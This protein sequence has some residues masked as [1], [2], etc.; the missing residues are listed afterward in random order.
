MR[1]FLDVAYDGTA[2]HGSQL[3]GAT[4]TVQ[5]AVNQALCT[6]LRVEINTWG[7]SRTDE[8][9]HA[10]H[11]VYHF[12]WD[13]PLPA[14]FLYNLNALLPQAIA[15][16]RL[17]QATDSDLNARFAALSR[18]YRYRIYQHKDPFLFQRA[19]YYPFHIEPEILRETSS[20][21]L[22]YR[23]FTSFAKRNAQTKTNNCRIYE[24]RWENHGKELHYV[25][26]ADRFLRG[27]VR[28]LVGTQL[29]VARGKMTLDAFQRIIEN[30][31]SSGA[32]FGVAGWG[33]YLERIEYP[34]G[35]LTLV[36]GHGK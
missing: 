24:S 22:Y 18:Q 15:A 36:Q 30:K 14:T 33:L 11:N 31:D 27:M 28:A 2:F 9:V 12:D 34:E 13:G 26:R 25:V 1:Y 6:L 10:L 3:Q 7:A 8:G 4:P 35:A 19:L 17:W 29:K 20:L 16:P 21:L 32:Y 5:L 23:D